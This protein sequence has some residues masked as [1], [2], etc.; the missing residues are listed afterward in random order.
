MISASVPQ[1]AIARTRQ[2]TS[3]AAGSGRGTSRISNAR[4]AVRTRASM[5]LFLHECSYAA[6]GGL[7]PLPAPWERADIDASA[8]HLGELSAEVLQH[9]D[10]I[11]CG[12]VMD[13]FEVPH[14]QRGLDRLTGHRLVLRD[15][16]GSHMAH[17]GV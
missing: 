15:E 14:W 17:A 6:D 13:V 12:G 3:F 11:P 8:G 7:A 4:G 1:I 16:I 10:V 2:R 5:G 9:R